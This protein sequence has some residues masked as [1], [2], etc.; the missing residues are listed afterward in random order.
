MY[1]AK[2][3]CSTATGY[4]LLSELSYSM[5]PVVMLYDQSENLKSKK[6]GSK[7]EVL[8]IALKT[9]SQQNCK[10]LTDSYIK[11]SVHSYPII[12]LYDRTENEKS[13]MAV[14]K[15]KFNRMMT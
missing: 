13:E 15:P 12:M 11:S 3:K 1:A 2:K 7:P 9:R 14:S 10:G 4:L 6:T 5:T 8:E